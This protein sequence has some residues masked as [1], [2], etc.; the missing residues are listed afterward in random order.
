MLKT[1]LGYIF[2]GFLV[3]G[4]YGFYLIGYIWD[5]F[6]GLC[7]S[8]NGIFELLVPKKLVSGSLFKCLTSLGYLG[9]LEFL[10]FWARGFGLW[11]LASYKKAFRIPGFPDF[12]LIQN[13][14]FSD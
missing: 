8:K 7:V 12:Q 6:R 4:I 2:H 9:F 14:Q 5:F 13:V 1:C 10:G 11:V 3:L